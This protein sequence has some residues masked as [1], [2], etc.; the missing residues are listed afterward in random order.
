[1]V[2]TATAATGASTARADEPVTP[3]R[4]N[5][6][7]EL[8]QVMRRDHKLVAAREALLTCSQPKCPGAIVQ[9]CGP[10]LREV[11][12]GMPSVVFVARDATGK[13]VPAV[14][15]S[16]EGTVLA[17]RLGGSA[18]AVDPG[19]R[20]FTFEPEHGKRVDLKL[21]VNMGEKNRLVVVT[22][23]DEVAA[24]AT[25]STTSPTLPTP[26][27]PAEGERGSLVPAIVVGGLGVAAL[28][29]SLGIYLDAKGGLNKLRDTCAPT[30]ATADV[31]SLKTK[32]ILSDVAFGVGLA[33]LG[34]AGV[35]ILL[36]APAKAATPAATTGLQWTLTPTAG[37]AAAGL[38]G[39]F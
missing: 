21:I 38:S 6:A 29:A 22:I 7:Y 2:A 14:K 23:A 17:T 25:T 36:R 32:G 16:V 10:W 11:E 15:V 34:A 1:M 5:A 12:S 8:A 35:M 24:P 31:D 19:E 20:T 33:G 27:P 13:D 39:R 28:G 9:D 4:C 18:L 3:Q 30:C 26:P 37:G